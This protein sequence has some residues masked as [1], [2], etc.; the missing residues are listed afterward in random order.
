MFE[1]LVESKIQEALERGEFD[2]LPGRDKPIDL[3]AYFETPPDFRLA[4]SVMKNAGVVPVEVELMQEID[5]LEAETGPGQAEMRRASRS[6]Q[7][8]NLRLRL[9]VLLETRRI[10]RF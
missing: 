4:H 8:Q 1:K 5:R 7:L 9:R 3:R 2:N 6:R 10:G